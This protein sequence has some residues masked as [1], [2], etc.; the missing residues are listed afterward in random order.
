M[1]YTNGTEGIPMNDNK[2]TLKIIPNIPK[3][4]VNAIGDLR[5]LVTN[6][7]SIIF[8]QAHKKVAT[9]AR[10]THDITL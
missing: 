2:I 8:T 10:I 3:D 5:N 1:K 6:T 7:L 9:K 4:A